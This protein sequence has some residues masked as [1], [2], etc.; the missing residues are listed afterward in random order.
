MCRRTNENV[1]KINNGL[2][3]I[4]LYI[5]DDEIELIYNLVGAINFPKEKESKI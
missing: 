4:L 2:T 5:E 1:S 3:W